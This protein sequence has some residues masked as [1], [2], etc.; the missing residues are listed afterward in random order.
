MPNFAPSTLIK[1]DPE[2]PNSKESKGISLIKDEINHNKHIQIRDKRLVRLAILK[3]TRFFSPIFL[4]RR[5]GRLA[6]G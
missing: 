5:M 4:P 2:K 1:A 3:I 6:P